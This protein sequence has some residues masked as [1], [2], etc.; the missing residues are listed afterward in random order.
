M[1]VQPSA[2]ALNM[3]ERLALADRFGKGQQDVTPKQ[4]RE[5]LDRL[6]VSALER[7]TDDYTKERSE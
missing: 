7:L 3:L 5:Y 2:Y 1:R 6:L 4:L